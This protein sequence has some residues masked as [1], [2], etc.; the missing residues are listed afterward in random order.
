M[1]TD[2]PC[3]HDWREAVNQRTGK[4]G[5]MCYRCGELKERKHDH[6]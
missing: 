6:R 3:K 4:M 2:K 5:K 1:T